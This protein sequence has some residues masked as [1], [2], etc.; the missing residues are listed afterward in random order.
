MV[1][2]RGNFLP[3]YILSKYGDTSSNDYPF[4][5]KKLRKLAPLMGKLLTKFRTKNNRGTKK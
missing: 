2:H 4:N 3:V 1:G 5:K